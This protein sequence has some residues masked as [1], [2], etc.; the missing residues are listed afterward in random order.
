[1]RVSLQS[2]TATTIAP[3]ALTPKSEDI[4]N[5]VTEQQQAGQARK[6]PEYA[7]DVHTERGRKAAKTADWYAD[8]RAMGVPV[9]TYTKKLADLT[10]ASFSDE[11]RTELAALES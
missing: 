11:L 4:Q 8:R 7:V 9:N 6:I 1:V 2:S 10:P 5:L 3:G